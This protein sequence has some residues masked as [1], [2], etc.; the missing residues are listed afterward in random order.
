MAALAFK[1]NVNKSTISRTVAKDLNIKSY[2]LRKCHLLTAALMERQLIKGTALLNE[3]KHGLSSQVRFFSDEK[4]FIQD[5]LHNRQNNR[6]ITENPEGVPI[7]MSTKFPTSVTVLGI[8]SSDGDVMHPYFFPE[9]LRVA[10]NNYIKVLK[11]VVKPWMVGVASKSPYVF[12]QDSAPV[13][14]AHMTQAWLY[15]QLPCHWPLDL[16][17][18]SSP[19][20]NPLDYYVWG[21]LEKVNYHPCNTKQEL[22]DAIVGAMDHMDRMKVKKACSTFRH[23]LK[24]VIE[25]KGGHIE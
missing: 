24:A 2:C 23:R 17:S 3:L 18:P 7:V 15:Q 14:M 16:W 5:K 25:K 4:K 10:T 21:V 1:I 6:F 19:D 20:L 11:T 22:K 13:H 9:G 12:Q 8:V